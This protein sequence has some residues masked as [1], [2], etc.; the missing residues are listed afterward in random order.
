MPINEGHPARPSDGDRSDV[1]LATGAAAAHPAWAVRSASAGCGHGLVP[2][3]LYSRFVRSWL[4]SRL[5]KP[6]TASVSSRDSALSEKSTQR[7]C[8]RTRPLPRLWRSRGCASPQPPTHDPV[9]TTALPGT[10]AAKGTR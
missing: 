7:L 5:V 3:Q 4:S 9:L 10:S 8:L 1:V 2:H 6:P